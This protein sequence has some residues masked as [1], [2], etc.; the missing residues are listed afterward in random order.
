MWEFYWNLAFVNLF[1]FITLRWFGQ[2]ITSRQL[3]LAIKLIAFHYISNSNCAGSQL[4]NSQTGF[5]LKK[6]HH[7]SWSIVCQNLTLS[8]PGGGVKYAPLLFFLHHPK[9]AQGIKLKL[10]D[11]K[12]TLLRHT[13]QVK[14][15]RYVLSRCHG[16]NITEGTSQDLAP[17]KSEKSAICRDIELKFGIRTNFGDWVQKQ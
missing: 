3:F 4:W 9:T 8:Y 11:F 6:K 7:S 17:Q 13:L 12:D 16:N 1:T 2:F 14:P 15:V 5:K 10:S